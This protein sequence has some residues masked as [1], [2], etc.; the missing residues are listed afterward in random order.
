MEESNYQDGVYAPFV[1]EE[2]LEARRSFIEKTYTFLAIEILCF[3]LVAAIFVNTPAIV[4]LTLSLFSGWWFLLLLGGYMAVINFAENWAMS[5][6][7]KPSQ[8]A[9][10]GLYIL[11]EA[12]LFTPLLYIALRLSNDLQLINQAAMI[13]VSLFLGITAVAFLT[14]KDYSA[15]RNYLVLGG[16][17]AMG[18]ILT[19]IL[20]GFSLGIWFSFGMVALAA[21]SILY[22]T[23]NILHKYHTGQHVAASLG[24]FGSVMLL[25]WYVI[26]ILISLSGD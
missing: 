11:A 26:N 12:L 20:F 17:I 9:A 6:T 14:K 25:F 23:S 8:Y 18:L 3:I 21:I 15:L 4:K 13:T 5:T 24:L 16:S 22:Q 10:M 1:G 2:P 19:G 7:S